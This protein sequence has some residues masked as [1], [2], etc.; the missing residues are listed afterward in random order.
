M[1]FPDRLISS[2]D[3]VLSAEHVVAGVGR[4]KLGIDLEDLGIIPN[5]AFFNFQGC[6][7]NMFLAIF[8]L[9]Y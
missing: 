1:Y 4:Q 3:G 9:K 6:H 7:E 5:L 8:F 2:G